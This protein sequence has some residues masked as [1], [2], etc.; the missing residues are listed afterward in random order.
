[1]SDEA[2]VR[3]CGCGWWRLCRLRARHPAQLARPT[4]ESA[5]GRREYTPKAFKDF[6]RKLQQIAK[7]AN[8]KRPVAQEPLTL[9]SAC[10]GPPGPLPWAWLLRGA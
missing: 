3:S 2:M 8:A 5:L 10:R 7:A 1:M 4:Q 9:R 6:R